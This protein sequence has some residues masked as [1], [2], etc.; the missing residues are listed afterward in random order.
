M[1]KHDNNIVRK[2]SRLFLTTSVYTLVSA[3]PWL[4]SQTC[5]VRKMEMAELSTYAAGQLFHLKEDSLLTS[6]R[7]D[8][9][10]FE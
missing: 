7:T 10:Y 1:S 3:S 8:N 5:S 6:D 4:R 9:D 2:N